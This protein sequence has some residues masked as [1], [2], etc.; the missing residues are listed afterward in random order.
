MERY[1][2]FYMASINHG[3]GLISWTGRYAKQLNRNESE[4]EGTIDGKNS[5]GLKVT[6]VVCSMPNTFTTDTTGTKVFDCPARNGG[7]AFA[8][9]T[10]DKWYGYVGLGYDGIQLLEG[11]LA[12][13]P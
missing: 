13:R 3:D 10:G 6:D 11:F 8:L 12:L 5:E 7:V 9:Q 4:T 2:D 1:R